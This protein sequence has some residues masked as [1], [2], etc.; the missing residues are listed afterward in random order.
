MNIAFRLAADKVEDVGGFGHDER[1]KAL[2][3]HPLA[4]ARASLLVL[5]VGE[6]L[7]AEVHVAK[8]RRD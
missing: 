6:Q 4:H 5:T 1:G 2:Q 3:I 7:G 8:D